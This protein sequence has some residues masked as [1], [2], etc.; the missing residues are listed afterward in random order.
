MHKEL[1]SGDSV[2]TKIGYININ[3]QECHGT[4]GEKGTDHLQFAYRLECLNCGFIYGAN[5][6]DVAE[7]KCPACQSGKQGIRYW[8]D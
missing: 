4:L 2:T 3:K 8:K 1:R 7:R 5:G 6:S